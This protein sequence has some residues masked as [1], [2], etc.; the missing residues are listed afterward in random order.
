MLTALDVAPLNGEA[1]ETNTDAGADNP[2][3]AKEA[4]NRKANECNDL[5]G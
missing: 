4:A 2:G 1:N 5:K 3:V